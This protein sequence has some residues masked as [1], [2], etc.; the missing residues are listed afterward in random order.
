M[1]L[2]NYLT[3]RQYLFVFDTDILK[4]IQIAHQLYYSQCERLEWVTSGTAKGCNQ[5]Y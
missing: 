2:L 5:M 1:Q 3:K 4:L